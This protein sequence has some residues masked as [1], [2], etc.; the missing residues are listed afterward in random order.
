MY[1][2]C[3]KVIIVFY[4]QMYSQ[5]E[6]FTI[7]WLPSYRCPI[8]LLVTRCKPF[9]QWTCCLLCSAYYMNTCTWCFYALVHFQLPWS[10]VKPV[11]HSFVE[12]SPHCFICFLVFLLYFTFTAWPLNFCLFCAVLSLLVSPLVGHSLPPLITRLSQIMTINLP[13]SDEIYGLALVS[14][15]LLSQELHI[16][17]NPIENYASLFICYLLMTFA[18]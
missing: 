7:L 17:C 13:W 10:L 4:K 12:F 8:I 9:V 15:R 1:V 2:F 14:I 6:S 3:G 18:N 16:D 11:G 5:Q